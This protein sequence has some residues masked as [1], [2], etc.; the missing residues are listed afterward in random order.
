M[1]VSNY[2]AVM[3]GVG[4][5][6]AHGPLHRSGRALLTHRAPALGSDA[7]THERL[8]RTVAARPC[9]RLD[10]PAR[11]HSTRFVRLCVRGAFCSRR[12]PLAS[13]LPSTTSAADASALFGGFPGTMGLS[14]FPRLFITG[15]RHL[16]SQCGLLLLWPQT[17]AGSPGSRARCV[18]ACLGSPTAQ[19]PRSSRSHDAPGVAFRLLE[20]RRHPEVA[21]ALAVVQTFRGSIPSLH[22][23]LSTLR[24]RPCGRQRMTRGRCGS[25]ALHRGALSSPTP[26]RF[27]RRT[28]DV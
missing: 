4:T 27:Y 16:T 3:V 13:P 24:S 5:M 6:V 11:A 2:S 28:P 26:C 7:K 15:V 8:G 1:I 21:T 10:V 19:G 20:R 14:D 9:S 12:F 22:F 17:D 23:P 25:L 18:C